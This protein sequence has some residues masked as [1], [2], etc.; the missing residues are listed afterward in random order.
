[1]YNYCAE[2]LIKAELDRQNVRQSGA[3]GMPT[4]QAVYDFVTQLVGAS[5]IEYKGSCPESA[6]PPQSGAHGDLYV[7]PRRRT[8]KEIYR[9]AR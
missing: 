1:M 3:P 7:R 4:T 8:Q 6:L 9:E 5:G 2:G